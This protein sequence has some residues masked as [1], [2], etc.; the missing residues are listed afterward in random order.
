MV[1]VPLLEFGRRHTDV[2]L[3]FSVIVRGHLGLIYYAFCETFSGSR[4]FIALLAVAL[5]VVGG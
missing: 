5:V 4:T 1:P 3:S 2:F